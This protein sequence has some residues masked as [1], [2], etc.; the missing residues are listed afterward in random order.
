MKDLPERIRNETKYASEYLKC[1]N[2]FRGQFQRTV[3]EDRDSRGQKTG[4]LA[5]LR[6]GAR[7]ENRELG[8]R[9]RG[10]TI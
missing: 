8:F 7:T 4:S 6:A 1:S 3:P 9:R 2:K 5:A 10:K